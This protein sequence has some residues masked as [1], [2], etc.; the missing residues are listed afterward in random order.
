MTVDFATVP[1]RAADVLIR[2]YQLLV[3]PLIGRNCR[4]F[5]SCSEYTRQAILKHGILMGGAYGARRMLK[6]HPFHPGGVDP[7]P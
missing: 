3:S 1:R 6:C 2:L 5:P 7:V 4:F